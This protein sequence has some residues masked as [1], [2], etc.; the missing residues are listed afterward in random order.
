MD[1]TYLFKGTLNYYPIFRKRDGN[2]CW[3]VYNGYAYMFPE[4]DMSVFNFIKKVQ[5]KGMII[6][7]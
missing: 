7:N 4:K 3:L 1:L 2:Y 5:G 6:Q